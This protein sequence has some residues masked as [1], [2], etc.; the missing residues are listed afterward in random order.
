MSSLYSIKKFEVPDDYIEKN[1][2]FN[3]FV[4]GLPRSGTSMM[5]HI[6]ELLGVKMI[7]TSEKNQ[8][9]LDVQYEAKFGKEYHPNPNGFFEITENSLEHFMEIA[10]TPYSGCKMIIPVVGIRWELVQ[11]LP[12]KVIVM[13]R[14]P[15]EVSESHDAFYSKNRPMSSAIAKTAL[16][17]EIVKLRENKIDF[18]EVKFSELF[19]NKEREV[20]RVKEFIN[21]G[22][23]I[24]AAVASIKDEL[25]RQRVVA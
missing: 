1:R 10:T 4:F 19:E 13:S 24:T 6:C 12:A 3:V 15:D 9:K 20:L 7:H 18:I 16:A 21:S 22:E 14:N 17:S 11:L 5:T 8:N 25:Y 23:D 2:L